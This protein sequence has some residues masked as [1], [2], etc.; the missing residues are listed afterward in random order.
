MSQ[1][2]SVAVQKPKADTNT[3]KDTMKRN[4]VMLSAGAQQQINQLKDIS[5]HFYSVGK[6]KDASG[7]WKEKLEPDAFALQTLATVQR[8]NT[9]VVGKTW[10]NPDNFLKAAVTVRVRGWKGDK[11]NPT[12][13]KTVELRMSMQTIAMRYVMDKLDVKMKWNNTTKKKEQQAS[14]WTPD[15]VEFEDNGM[16]KPKDPRKRIAMLSY[17]TDQY[18]FLDRTAESKA[19]RRLNMKLLGFDWRDPDEITSET[20]EVR[21]VQGAKPLEVPQVALDLIQ[22]I[23]AAET[24]EA[25]EAIRPEV[26]KLAGASEKHVSDLI[27]SKFSEKLQEAVAAEVPVAAGIPEEQVQEFIE[28]F[29]AHETAE[30]I[31]DLWNDVIEPL[32]T[33]EDQKKRLL[34]AKEKALSALSK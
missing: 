25:I 22:K 3:V 4:A 14:D 30:G 8:I 7:E 20:G 17:L 27:V 18:A 1:S 19:E 5:N 28:A 12:I 9:E 34:E 24:K 11:E 15:D 6:Y 29:A 21:A 26:E 2:K 23:D 33:S 13:E 16:C 32:A 10:E 31:N